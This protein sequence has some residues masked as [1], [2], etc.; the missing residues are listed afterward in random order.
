MKWK[1]LGLV[2]D[3]RKDL[4]GWAASSA[5]TPMPTLHRDGFIR[6]YAGFR[7]AAGISRIGY[8]D[9]AADDPARVLGVSPRPALDVGRDGCFD[10]NGVILG[11]VVAHDGRLYLFYVGFQL[12]AKA[13]FLALTGLAVSDDGGD[14][15]RRVSE[16]PFLG[17]AD[18]QTMIAAIH[19][20]RFE[21]G[22]WQFW[23]AAGND[24]EIIGGKPFPRYEIRYL[25]TASLEP[26]ARLGALC[27]EPVRPEYRIGRPRVYRTS[28]GY[29][30]HFTKGTTCGD[31]T[32]GAATSVD[33]IHWLREGSAFDLQLSASGWDSRHLCYPVMLE[34]GGRR[35]MF[36]NG[37]DMGVDGFGCAVLE[38]AG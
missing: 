36:Y 24:W 15:F 37:N 26:I 5:L 4:P 21:A 8:V 27:L 13:K 19:T 11:D 20:A 14:T 6:V 32:P 25:D 33:G 18:G 10:D 2:F 7:D 31:Y 9:L 30:M 17:R 34:A 23:Y 1:K 35:Y 3:A 22:R 16:G 12:V 28:D 38:Q 29:L